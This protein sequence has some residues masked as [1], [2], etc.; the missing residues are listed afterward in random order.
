MKSVF[1]I[2]G[3][4]I[5][6]A[7]YLLTRNSQPVSSNGWGD[8]F[9][10]G[11]SSDTWSG[12]FSDVV[13]H[14]VEIAE[15]FSEMQDST[16]EVEIV[17]KV[18]KTVPDESHSL[19]GLG[20]SYGSQNVISDQPRSLSDIIMDGLSEFVKNPLAG[21][22][23]VVEAVAVAV[24]SPPVEPED[25][26]TSSNYKLVVG[27]G[28]RRLISY[29]DG[30]TK[31]GG[32]RSWRNNNSGNIEYGNFARSHGAIGTD[33]RFAIFPTKAAGD[34]AKIALLKGSSYRNRTITGAILRYAPQFENNSAW[35]AKT[36]AGAA[37]VSVN[38]K[39]TDLTDAQFSLM[40][41]AMTSVEGWKAGTSGTHSNFA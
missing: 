29:P 7:A 13:N 14:Q 4:S 37:G 1:L 41:N 39:L 36:I 15:T 26:K 9:V 35:Y 19:F 3:A 10:V 28:T 20:G 24:V 40:V 17:K 2:G 33:G 11:A 27:S 31:T 16:K 34:N 32:S 23:A 22:V 18:I 5:G 12:A 38:T 6:L 8:A 25:K 21:G 30:T